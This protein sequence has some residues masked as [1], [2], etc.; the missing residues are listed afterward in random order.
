MLHQTTFLTIYILVIT[1]I[2]GCALGSFADCLAGRMLKGESALK[3][4]S[5]CDFCG[6]VLGAADLIPLLSWLCL[7]GRCRYCGRKISSESFFTELISGIACCLIVYRY[8][9]SV[10]AV[11]GILFWM[12]L[13]CLT[14]TDLHEYIIPDRLQIAGIVIYVGTAVLMTDPVFMI[15][16]GLCYGTGLAVLML[17]L[18]LIFDRLSGKESLGGGDIKLF[19]VTGLYMNSVWAILFFLILSCIFGLAGSILFKKN[20]IPFGPAIAAA[21]FFMMLYGDILTQWYT[22]LFVS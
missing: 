8:D 21:C 6:H 12:V 9:I 14:L 18:S 2:L 5:H 7:K 10:L 13:M 22:G 16:T 1:F 11:R 19:F 3:G 20:K 15:V 17:V 4:R